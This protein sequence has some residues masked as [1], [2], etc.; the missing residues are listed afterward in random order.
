MTSLN[1]NI[2]EKRDV[3]RVLSQIQSAKHHEQNSFLSEF[4][5]GNEASWSRFL[6]GA[7]S[8]PVTW[9]IGIIQLQMQMGVWGSQHKAISQSRAS[10]L[11]QVTS[12][13]RDELASLGTGSSAPILEAIVRYNLKHR[14]ADIVGRFSGGVFTNYASTG[15]RFGNARLSPTAKRVRAVT[16][17]SIASYG[18]AIKAIAEG[19]RTYQAVVQAILTGKPEEIKLNKSMNGAGLSSEESEVLEK[20]ATSTSDALSL[21]HVSPPPIPTNEFCARPENINLRGVCR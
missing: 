14:K 21:I 20:L 4:A 1:L 5:R 2:S 12:P 7:Y 16:N 9:W 18:A 8:H 3:E 10:V 15:G 11:W 19:M 17:L 13:V 6:K